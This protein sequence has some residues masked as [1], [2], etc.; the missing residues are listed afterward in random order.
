[1]VRYGSPDVGF[2]LQ[3][4]RSLLADLTTHSIDREAII[5][6]TTV[7]G[8]ADEQHAK[9][10]INKAAI[11]QEG[12]FDD[13]TDRIHDA[14][15]G[16]TEEI[17]CVSDAGNALPSAG[18][19]RPCVGI[20]GQIQVNYQRAASRGELHKASASY[21]ANGIVEECVLLAHHVARTAD[22]GDT[23]STSH[24]NAASSAAGGAAYLQVSALALGGFTNV[25]EE[26]AK[27]NIERQ[28]LRLT[29]RGLGLQE[30]GLDI[31]ERGQDI[32]AQTSAE[33][34]LF[35]REEMHK[36]FGQQKVEFDA[37]QLKLRKDADG[38]QMLRFRT[39]IKELLDAGVQPDDRRIRN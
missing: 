1:M 20:K 7:L 18:V 16:L 13:G 35:E 4:G 31:R 8:D 33:R 17:A 6:E 36:R 38:A 15:V 19:A 39:T 28:R 5:E 12:F 34:L 30:R 9:V 3:G 24:D 29:E 11:T 21:K 14:L 22:P 27:R 2:I 37:K 32:T 25:Q 10:G 26:R 23:E